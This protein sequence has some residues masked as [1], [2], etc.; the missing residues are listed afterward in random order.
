MINYYIYIIMILWIPKFSQERDRPGHYPL[1]IYQDLTPRLQ[2]LLAPQCLF[3]H[4]VHYYV[5]HI[6]SLGV[7][8]CV[9]L[10]LQTLLLLFVIQR[11]MESCWNLLHFNWVIFNS[12]SGV[13][14][15]I[16][17]TLCQSRRPDLYK[18]MLTRTHKQF[19][20]RIYMAHSITNC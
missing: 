4:F 12:V 16:L 3:V 13:F 11:R 8:V 14:T 9:V 20:T 17:P 1:A 5:V 18:N 2:E 19:Y 15:K 7:C 6:L 10:V